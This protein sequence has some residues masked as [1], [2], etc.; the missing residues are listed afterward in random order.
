MIPGIDEKF[1]AIKNAASNVKTLRDTID[2]VRMKIEQVE[3]NS[4]GQAELPLGGPVPSA[5]CKNCG[6]EF[7]ACG[8]VLTETGNACCDT[9]VHPAPEPTTGEPGTVIDAEVPP[10][11]SPVADGE[12]PR[13]VSVEGAFPA[14]ACIHCVMAKV[15]CDEALVAT[16]KLC[17]EQCSH[18]EA[19]ALRA[20]PK[21]ASPS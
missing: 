16:E 8:D 3:K 6:T 11:A 21:E 15:D 1:K 4:S 9:C 14:R 13:G 19:P 12:Q 10:E 2:I 20:V 5:P 18:P 17:C 7:S